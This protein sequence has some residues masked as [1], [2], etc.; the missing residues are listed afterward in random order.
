VARNYAAISILYL[1]F[2]E[3]E[4][5]QIGANLGDN[6]ARAAWRASGDPRIQDRSRNLAISMH[7]IAPD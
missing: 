6:P 2:D 3:A 4:L 1:R 7:R 5:P